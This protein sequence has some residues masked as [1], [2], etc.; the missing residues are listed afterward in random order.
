MG[1]FNG[2]TISTNTMAEGVVDV[3]PIPALNSGAIVGDSYMCG[4]PYKMQRI[5]T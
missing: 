3:Y 5:Q 1:L 4:A 2:G